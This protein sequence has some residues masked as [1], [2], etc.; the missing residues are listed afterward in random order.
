MTP[1]RAGTFIYHTHWHDI[2][3]LRGGLNGPL[4]VVDDRYDPT[5]DQVFVAA[6]GP[7]E[8]QPLILNGSGAPIALD[9]AAGKTYHLRFINIGPNIPVKF[10]ILSAGELMKWKAVG[11]DGMELPEPQRIEGAASQLVAVGE[12][13]DFEMKAPTA[14][15]VV[16]RA[17]IAENPGIIQELKVEQAIKVRTATEV[18]A[19]QR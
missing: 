7:D 9:W 19:T 11:K 5:S 15:E 13:Y 2:A 18:A 12:T 4:I 3:Q 10:S 16:V 17:F 14:G 6:F 8:K 1:P